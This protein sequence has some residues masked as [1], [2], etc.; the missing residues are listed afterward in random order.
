MGFDYWIS[1]FDLLHL[2]FFFMKNE[3]DE[4]L[5]ERKTERFGIWKEASLVVK[6]YNVWEFDKCIC[7]C[8]IGEKLIL[9]LSSYSIGVCLNFKRKK[10]KKEKKRGNHSP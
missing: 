3:E 8:P 7:L 10:R 6:I 9:T 4:V 5:R 1:G 2:G